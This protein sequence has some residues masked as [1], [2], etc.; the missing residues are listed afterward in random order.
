V[1]G[2]RRV[3]VRNDWDTAV[4]QSILEGDEYRLS[5]LA[6]CGAVVHRVVDVGAH[7]GSFTLCAKRHWP[8]ARV[9]AVEPAPDSA[10]YFQ[11]NTA[12]S[13]GVLLERVALVAQGGP[14][15]TELVDTGD[16]NLGGRYV[17]CIVGDAIPSD[18]TA[19]RVP[20]TNIGAL[21]K[22]H[23]W[24]NVD[25]LKL[26]C[27]GAEGVILSELAAAGMLRQVRFICGEWHRFPTIPRIVQA[28]RDTHHLNVLQ[29][30]DPLG[31]FFAVSKDEPAPGL[32]WLNG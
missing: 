18:R 12:G 10:S 32:R 4:A 11:L 17:P 8:G 6:A 14:A 15:I 13:P 16:E 19:T 7:I 25:L 28:L 20:T 5:P 1:N 27:E 26:D 3:F 31:L 23:R 21:L 30:L 9:L 22:N 2:K 24:R 29:G